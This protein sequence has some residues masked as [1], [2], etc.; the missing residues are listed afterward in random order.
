MFDGIH[1]VWFLDPR[2]LE[3]ESD[4]WMVWYMRRPK[5]ATLRGE[6]VIPG[7]DPPGLYRGLPWEEIY[8]KQTKGPYFDGRNCSFFFFSVFLFFEKCQ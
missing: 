2:D 7:R 6:V 1:D 4:E 3:P 8:T 5:E